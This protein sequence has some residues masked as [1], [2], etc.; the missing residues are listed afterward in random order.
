MDVNILERIL[1]ELRAKDIVNT[2]DSR[3]NE[4]A[5][6][7]SSKL[8][9]V[10]GNNLTFQTGSGTIPG[11]FWIQKVQLLELAKALEPYWSGRTRNVL[12]A[13]R[14]AV[15]GNIK[16]SCNCPA[17]RY[18]GFAYIASQGKYKVGRAQTR[19]PGIRNPHL[20][21]SVCKHLINVLRVLPFN[22]PQIV[23]S[24]RKSGSV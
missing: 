10:K 20:R 11:T 18:W 13:V 24:A 2:A 15:H 12:G 7:L 8:L 4:R 17:M 14:S 3:S 19:F 1:L 16:V 6:P 23:K 22:M 9:R 21:G 5:K